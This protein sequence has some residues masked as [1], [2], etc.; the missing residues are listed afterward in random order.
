[1]AY[2]VVSHRSNNDQCRH[3]ADSIEQAA[4]VHAR[5]HI[6]R[7][8]VAQRTTGNDGLSGYFQAYYW[9]PAPHNSQ[10]SIDEPF[11]VMPDRS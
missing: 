11:H 1:M 5:R 9:L 6:R 3:R 4:E 8:A 7:N 10:S 2:Y